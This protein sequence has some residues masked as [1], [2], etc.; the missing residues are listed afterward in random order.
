MNGREIHQAQAWLAQQAD[1]LGTLDRAIALEQERL[2]AL[3][4][5]RREEWAKVQRYERAAEESDADRDLA[6][7]YAEWLNTREQSGAGVSDEDLERIGDDLATTHWLVAYDDD[8]GMWQVIHADGDPGADG[9]DQYARERAPK[10]GVTIAGKTYRGGMWIPSAELAKADPA[11]REKIDAAQQSHADRRRARG[12]DAHAL[13]ETLK[14][15]QAELTAKERANAARAFGALKH[16]HGDL[17]VHRLEELVQ[18]D[19]RGLGATKGMMR[20]YLEK[21]LARH[22]HVLDMARAHPDLAETFRHKPHV[23]E[24]GGE[25][26]LSIPDKAGNRTDYLVGHVKPQAGESLALRLTNEHNGNTYDVGV[27]G[28]E[29]RCSCPGFKHHGHC[30]HVDSV[31][32]LLAGG[33]LKEPAKVAEKPAEPEPDEPETPHVHTRQRKQRAFLL[34]MTFQLT[35]GCGP[36]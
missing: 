12:V 36:Q 5:L 10:G 11:T 27:K 9:A 25:R 14:P 22:A 26:H 34:A 13:A 18:S 6:D 15:H 23:A 19:M 16:H 17:L 8:T 24:K 29:P 35:P 33:G 21:Q 20:D 7:Y 3:H 28:G 31:K 1:P 30:K 2:T 4:A 32:E